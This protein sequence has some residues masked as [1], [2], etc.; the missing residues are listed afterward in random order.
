MNSEGSATAR[1]FGDWSEQ[2]ARPPDPLAR[3]GHLAP[4]PNPGELRSKSVRRAQQPDPESAKV[5][6][7]P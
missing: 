3:I 5:G 4:E 1:A 2:T 6:A 7:Q